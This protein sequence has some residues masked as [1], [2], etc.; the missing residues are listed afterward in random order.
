MN[1]A[2]QS[3][4]IYVANTE[5]GE[6]KQLTH[7][8]N[9]NI[10]NGIFDWVYEGTLP[11]PIPISVIIPSPCC[12]HCLSSLP[13]LTSFLPNPLPFPWCSISSL[14][15]SH[16]QITYCSSMFHRGVSSPR[17]LPLVSRFQENRIL[18]HRSGISPNFISILTKGF[19]FNFLCHIG[20]L[21]LRLDSREVFHVDGWDEALHGDFVPQIPQGR[22]TELH[23]QSTRSLSLF[24]TRALAFLPEL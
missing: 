6:V 17:G 21:T 8:G 10:L 2:F 19:N 23:R 4:N 15:H 7:D 3:S 5:T 20:P 24:L 13:K 22:R 18:A 11:V 14:T 9:D 12:C 1:S 16:R